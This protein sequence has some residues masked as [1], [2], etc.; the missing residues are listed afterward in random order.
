MRILSFERRKILIAIKLK[1]PNTS[2]LKESI[3]K[4]TSVKELSQTR[5]KTKEASSKL[6]SLKINANKAPKIAIN[7]KG[8]FHGR[9]KSKIKVIIKIT[10]ASIKIFSFAFL[11]KFVKYLKPQG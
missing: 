8:K 9:Q 6:T 10:L 3:I 2:K 5:S 11:Y 7:H 4:P 1:N